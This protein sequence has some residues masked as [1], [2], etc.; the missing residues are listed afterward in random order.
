MDGLIDNEQLL[1]LLTSHQRRLTGYLRTLVANR[2]DAEELLQETNL[3]IWR[4]A[5]EFALGTDFGAWALR[6]AHFRVLEW[7]QR[8]SR[9]R[10]VFDDTLLDLLVA[11]A[12]SFD[13]QADRNQDA[14]EVCLEKLAP[15]DHALI[16]QL[17]N[18][19]EATPHSLAE[20]IGRS[21]K[22]IYVSLNRIHLRL[23]KC[24]QRTLAAEER[25]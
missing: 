25:V 7:R 19:P 4:H 2:A 20:R 6:I 12:Q 22:G 23:L 17:Y 16:M 10:L 9:D 3:Y 11:A 5:K 13:T 14:L 15:H 1:S 21:A 24:I 18:D 8:R